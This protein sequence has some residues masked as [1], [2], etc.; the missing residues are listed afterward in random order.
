[1]RVAKKHW[2]LL[3]EHG[4]IYGMTVYKTLR[5]A[6]NALQWCRKNLEVAIRI[7]ELEVKA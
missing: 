3:D 2:A 6:N 1:M 4:F 5:D 7:V